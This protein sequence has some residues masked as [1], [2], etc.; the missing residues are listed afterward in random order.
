MERRSPEDAADPRDES[1]EPAP[2][3]A[4]EGEKMLRAPVTGHGMRGQIEARDADFEPLAVV[5]SND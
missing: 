5:A 1:H 2:G 3:T 4:R